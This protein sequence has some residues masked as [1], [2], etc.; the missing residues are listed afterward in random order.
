MSDYKIGIVVEGTTDRI[1]IESA[2]NHIF[3]DQ[4]YTMIQ[5]QPERNF[6]HGGFDSTGAGWG[7][8]YRWCRQVVDMGFKISENPSLKK[9]DI[10]IIHL[11]ADVAEKDTVMQVF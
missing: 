4:Y 5:L 1:I 11:D 2:L 7:G 3:Q 10:I 8:V 6:Q 9:F